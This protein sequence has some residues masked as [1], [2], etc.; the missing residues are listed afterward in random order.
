MTFSFPSCQYAVSM[1]PT[2]TPIYNKRHVLC[3][4]LVTHGLPVQITALSKINPKLPCNPS[5]LATLRD[6]TREPVKLFIWLLLRN[7]NE[8]SHGKPIPTVGVPCPSCLV[9][10][11]ALNLKLC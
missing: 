6:V 10:S 8:F 9:T 7:S 5:P 2:R 1:N 11:P 4:T 3:A